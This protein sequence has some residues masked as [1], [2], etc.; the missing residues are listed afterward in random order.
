M[1]RLLNALIVEDSE[2]DAV[3]VVRVLRQGGFDVRGERVENATAM[4]AAL[5]GG[6]WD[7]VIS[8]YAMPHFNGLSALKVLHESGL[9]LPF[10]LVS[11]VV[12][13]EQGVEAMRLGAH[14]YVMKKNL[15]R[16]A[17]AVERE[18]REAE[19]RRQR[20]RMNDEVHR[21][22]QDLEQRVAKRTA[23]LA[24]KNA[25]LEDFA[26]S[27]ANELHAPLRQIESA[28]GM[29]AQS[30][31][32]PGAQKSLRD[33][34]RKSRRMADLIGNLQTLFQIGRQPLKLQATGLGTVVE[35]ALLELQAEIS[36][37]DIQWQIED[38]PVSTCDGNLVR[39]VLENLL[40]N[41]VKSTAS[42]KPAVIQVGKKTVNDE[43]AI[44]V[45]DN[46]LGFDM[47]YAD[48]LF[49]AFQHLHGADEN[50][51]TG[52]GLAIAKR[53]VQK[54]GGRIWAETETGR[55]ATFYF[56][57]GAAAQPVREPE[58]VGHAS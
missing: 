24:A 20:R 4:R 37:R 19:I 30:L 28:C 33:L 23:E 46:G 25:E 26:F 40:S 18:L 49:G 39:R 14:D 10:I 27:I 12:G 54:H 36:G 35:G 44:F 22:N 15:P 13:E 17:P 2:D 50:E 3:L 43:M 21:L 11:G 48:R 5:T 42:R 31:N 16:L 7:I 41:A 38:L 55:G 6:P 53:I 52:L 56:T 45:R 34:A 29:L 57:L 58:L 1:P 32:D 51:G 47:D 8:D 9:D